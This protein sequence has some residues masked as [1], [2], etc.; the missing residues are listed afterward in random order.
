METKRARGLTFGVAG[1]V[2][3]LGGV[4]FVGSIPPRVGRTTR[5]RTR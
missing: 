5:P 4:A 3:A 2:A 1:V